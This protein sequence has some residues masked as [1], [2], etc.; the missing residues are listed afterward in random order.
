MQTAS[1]VLWFLSLS[2][3]VL[4]D[5]TPD[6]VTFGWNTEEMLSYASQSKRSKGEKFNISLGEKATFHCYLYRSPNYQ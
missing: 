6:S 2:D 3:F 4:P 1:I 5:M